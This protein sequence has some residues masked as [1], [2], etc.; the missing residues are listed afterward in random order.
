MEKEY[1]QGNYAT[2]LLQQYKLNETEEN[3]IYELIDRNYRFEELKKL[4]FVKS[5]EKISY[6]KVQKKLI[7]DAFYVETF[8]KYSGFNFFLESVFEEK[9]ILRPLEDAMNHFKD[10]AKQGYDPIYE[11]EENEVEEIWEERKA[12]DG[13]VFDVDPIVYI[14]KKKS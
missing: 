8:V 14:K 12:I 5:S 2:Y 4:G 7:Q 9:Y 3:N 1:R 6:I 11:I 10:F 13:F